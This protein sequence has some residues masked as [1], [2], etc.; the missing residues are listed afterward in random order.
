MEEK[1]LLKSL[2][3]KLKEINDIRNLNSKDLKFKSWHISTINTLKRLPSSHS[4]EVNI[5]KKL[6]FTDTKYHRGKKIFNPSDERK[7]RED[8]DSALEI[9]KKITSSKK[10]SSQKKDNAVKEIPIKKKTTA[11]KLQPSKKR[12]STKIPEP[13]RKAKTTKSPSSPKKPASRKK[14]TNT[15]KTTNSKKAPA[16]K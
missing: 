3:S 4:R 10:T 1:E 9:L 15:T 14:P 5:F 2:R 7:Y 16:K 6:N 12:K 8:L 11:K 13:G